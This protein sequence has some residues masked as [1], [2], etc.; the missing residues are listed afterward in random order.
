[1]DRAIEIGHEPRLLVGRTPEHHAVDVLELRERSVAVDEAAVDHDPQP[2]KSR[3]K[4][5]TRG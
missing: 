5:C 4:R 1:M 3:F 2:A